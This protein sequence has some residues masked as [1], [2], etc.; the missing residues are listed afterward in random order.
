VDL[1]TGQRTL[2]KEIAAP[3]PT[4]APGRIVLSPDGLS[5]AYSYDESFSDLY[6]IE[7]LQ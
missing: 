6:L 7:G 1:E 3:T 5:Y 2:W 4:G